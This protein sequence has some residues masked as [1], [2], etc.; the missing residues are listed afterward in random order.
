MA[1]ISLFVLL[2][3]ALSTS[4]LFAPNPTSGKISEQSPLVTWTG[5]PMVS[6]A[7][8]NCGGPNNS[9]CDNFRLEIV[10][11]SFNYTVEIRLAPEL[12][13]DWDL[14]VYGPDGKLLKGSG[15]SPGQPEL[16]AL[17][18]LPAGIYTVTAAP[19]LVK[20]TYT[21]S[22]RIVPAQTAPPASTETA[23]IYAA[24]A[25]PPNMGRDAGEPTLGLSEKSGRAMFIAGLETLRITFDDCSSPARALWEDVSFITTSLITWDP[26]LFMDQILG[27]TFV[28]QLQFPAKQTSMAF[29]DDDGDSWL[30][31]QGSGITT[32]VD[33]QT[34]GGGPFPPG[35]IQPLTDYAHA[36]Y[37]A[38][39]DLALAEA[40]VSQNGGVTF[41]PGIPMYNSTECGGLHGHL[42]V[43]PDGTAYV[44]N[45]GCG[46][47]QAI[48][49]STDAGLNWKVRP[50]PDSTAG[51]WDP[52]VGIA[53][54]GTLYF[55][56]GAA[57][58]H[59]YVAVSRDRGVTW[60]KSIDVGAG[61]GIEN[62]AF[63]AMVAGDPDRAAFAFLGTTTAGGASGDDPNWPGAWYLHIAHTYDGGATW[64]VSNAT[65]ND[66]VQRGTI[67]GGGFGGCDNGTRNLL[68][69]MDATVDKQG[70]VLV[71]YADG[72]IGGCVAAPPNSFTA[73]ASVA[74]QKTGKRLF[75]ASDQLG[76]PAAP[77]TE[78]AQTPG[79]TAIH[80]K[81]E[82]PDDR[83]SAITQYRIYRRASSTPLSLIAS[84]AADVHTYDDSGVSAGAAYFYQ[85][86]AVNSFGEGPG[87]EIEAKVV[88]PPPPVD[89]CH[90]PGT[91]VAKDRVGDTPVGALDIESLHIAE[92]M[93]PDGSSNVVFTLKVR[94]LSNF[95]PG[96]AWLVIWQRPVPDP[97]FDRNYVA[98][99][100]TGPNTAVFKYGKV[101][102]PSI[103]QGTDLGDADAGSFAP[104]G[105]IT[106][107]LSTSKA[108]GV[109]VG[110]DL[111][112]IEVRTFVA[113]VSGQPV[114]GLTAT[115]TSAPSNYTLV[116][117]AGCNLNQPPV[118][119]DDSAT[120]PENKPVQINVL[121][122]DSDPNGDVLTITALTSPA[123]GAAVAKKHG[124]VS[125]KPN[126]GFT[127]VDT[128]TYTISD[129]KGGTD[130]GTVRV[131]VNPR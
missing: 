47:R 14:Q 36:V 32:G 123:N 125:Y 17:S 100:S 44:P 39:Q 35:L 65:P 86:R 128:F 74:R 119:G 21:A 34:V 91:P 107:T 121:A 16:A 60:S 112:G 131:T 41:G 64:T 50:V 19:F 111:S 23:P 94:D 115:D 49:V 129:G 88:P 8:S 29:T 93:Y 45:K 1:R 27:R 20:T 2:A 92:P 66:P 67:C 70:R 103:N 127:G 81:W 108:D 3:L 77:L 56:Y 126:K 24:Y 79:S 76:V 101:S 40:A 46:G 95:A 52:S 18:N 55:G 37:V 83:G 10:P 87:C 110:Q 89:T 51:D 15:N 22:A 33:H 43:G 80:L 48:I 122:N 124:A 5:G 26:I 120:T 113:N 96:N 109:K 38:A 4:F 102:P 63:P 42:K 90:T 7:M 69:F 25:A 61:I 71:A 12:A 106:I 84:V 73:V 54:D 9:L 78:A 75:K 118:A 117:S 58:G 57:N 68:D 98:M 30:P 53:S 116:G 13:D 62:I 85:V 28:S 82:T 72:C 104:D 11:S 114:T 59:A 130:T 31:S 6:T 97:G 99:R 105:T